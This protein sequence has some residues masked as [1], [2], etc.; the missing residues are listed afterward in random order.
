MFA[1]TSGRSIFG[2]RIEPRSPPVQVTTCTSTP[3]ATYLAVVAAP[4][5]DSSSGW[6]CTCI[7]RN[8]AAI[9]G[10]RG[11]P[12]HARSGGPVRRCVPRSP[13]TARRGR[14]GAGRGRR[15]LGGVGGRRALAAGGVLAAGGLPRGRPA[16]GHRTVHRG[17]A[18]R[19]R[20]RLVPAA[21]LRRG[22]LRRRRA[23]GAGGVGSTDPVGGGHRPDR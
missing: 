9:L 13:A 7:K 22:P 1:S 18:R 4:L 8:M 21:R 10:W 20:T 16:R 6:A 17:Q 3:S 2:F 5:L 14:G 12:T 19:R 11:E 15:R 23:A